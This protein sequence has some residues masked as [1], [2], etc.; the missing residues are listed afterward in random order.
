[1]F[2]SEFVIDKTQASIDRDIA[3]SCHIEK[4]K[5]SITIFLSIDGKVAIDR[6]GSDIA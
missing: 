3:H 4:C 1:M 5:F 6:N 2:S